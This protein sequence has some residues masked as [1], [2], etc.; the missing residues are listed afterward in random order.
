MT[1][2]NEV[3]ERMMPD[4]RHNAIRCEVEEIRDGGATFW[5]KRTIE[6]LRFEVGYSEWM[7]YITSRARHA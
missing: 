2:T 6:V 5:V 7:A 4:G 3:V 1:K